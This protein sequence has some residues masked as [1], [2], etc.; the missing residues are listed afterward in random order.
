MARCIEEC[1]TVV[2]R[3]GSGRYQG[4]ERYGE[5]TDMLGDTP[6]FT[7]SYGCMTQGI[8][9]GSLAVIYMALLVSFRCTV[10][11]GLSLP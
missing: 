11:G 4:R 2:G 6:C 3:I 10:I 8:E 9:E 1:Y 5:S 7:C